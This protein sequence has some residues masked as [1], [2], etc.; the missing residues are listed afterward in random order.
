MQDVDLAQGALDTF[1]DVLDKLNEQFGRRI[2]GAS[3]AA[4][5]NFGGGSGY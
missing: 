5:Y 3:V 4:A 2:G 1:A